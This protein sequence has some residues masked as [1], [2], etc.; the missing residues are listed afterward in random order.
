MSST[1]AIADAVT[2]A[3]LLTQEVQ[4]PREMTLSGFLLHFPIPRGGEAC[5]VLKMRGGGMRVSWD[6]SYLCP[7]DEE[8]GE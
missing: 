6:G 3:E 2:G 8:E 7:I 1:S 5:A 4:L